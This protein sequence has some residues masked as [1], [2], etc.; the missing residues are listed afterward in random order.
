MKIQNFEFFLGQAECERC[1]C[2]TLCH[3]ASYPFD[4]L[5]AEGHSCKR[6]G[7]SKVP[8]LAVGTE[9]L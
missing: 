4:R 7:E 8:G 1:S 5:E 9:T 3:K 2:T 6:I